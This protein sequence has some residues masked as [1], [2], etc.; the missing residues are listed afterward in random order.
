M[1]GTLVVFDVD[2]TS[3]TVNY[4]PAVH[5]SIVLPGGSPP[6]GWTPYYTESGYACSLGQEGRGISQH[7]TSLQGAT[8]TLQFTGVFS[9]AIQINRLY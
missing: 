4:Y 8:L 2:D 5:N 1:A 6:V 9:V 3:P 7:R